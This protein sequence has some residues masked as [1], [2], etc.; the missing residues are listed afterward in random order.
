MLDPAVAARILAEIH[1]EEIVKGCCDVINIPSPTGHE[2][3]MARHMRAQFEQLGLAIA[4]Q[5]VEDGRA[6]VVGRWEGVGDGPNLMFN[7]HMDTSNTGD[8]PFLTGIG[9]KPEAVVRDGTIYGLGI[10]NMKGA[11]VCYVHA[12]K[13]LQRAGVRLRGDVIL[14]AVAGEIEKAQWGEFTG[15]Q[16]RGYGVGSHYL[17]NHGVLPDMCILGEPTDMQLVL[18]HY[19]SLWVRFSTKGDYVHTA[20]A[21]G[22]EHENAVRR[23]HHVITD[24]LTWAEGWNQ[25]ACCGDRRGTVNIGCIRAGHPWRASRTPESCDLFLDVRVPPS[26]AMTDARRRVQALYRQLKEQYPDYGLEFETYVSVPGAEISP[27]HLMVRSIIESHTTVVGTAPKRN[28]V[29]WCS[30][31][32]VLSRYGIPTVNYGPSSGPRD[33]E[34]E[35]VKIQTL[36]DITKV[37]ALTAAR[38]CGI[39]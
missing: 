1:E 9:Y 21:A 20:F 10:Y 22:H 37:Y 5:E 12:L 33:A 14:G 39:A 24:V 36:V 23:M 8:E 11:L 13:A 31:A 4:W 7:G 26:I 25:E 17:V 35:K 27:E 32:S 2:W 30:D 3:E 34:G 6:N 19:G 18:E 15:K 28:T 16:Y 29:L 38:I